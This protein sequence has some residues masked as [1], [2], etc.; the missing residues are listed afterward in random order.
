V[1][2]FVTGPYVDLITL[3]GA[4]R[5]NHPQLLQYSRKD[6]TEVSVWAINVEHSEDLE[7]VLEERRETTD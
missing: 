5:D 7:R 3:P 4:G 6:G 2:V 1:S